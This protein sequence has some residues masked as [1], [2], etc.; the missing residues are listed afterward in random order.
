MLGAHCRAVSIPPCRLDAEERNRALKVEVQEEVAA[1]AAAAEKAVAEREMLQS[2]LHSSEADLAA[3]C[4]RLA[5][6]RE[7][8]DRKLRE[9][10]E[11]TRH[12]LHPACFHYSRKGS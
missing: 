7:E 9:H 3:T 6:D 1:A 12:A 11:S 8:S 5:A 4:A 2:K 10:W